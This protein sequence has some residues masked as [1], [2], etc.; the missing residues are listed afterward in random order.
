MRE[1][2]R[3]RVLRILPRARRLAR[4]GRS[5]HGIAVLC[6]VSD[7]TVKRMLDPSFVPPRKPRRP[8]EIWQQN[9]VRTNQCHPAR[10]FPVRPE[11]ARLR[12]QIV[13]DFAAGDT[14]LWA[15]RCAAM[16]RLLPILC[17]VE[18]RPPE[19]RQHNPDKKKENA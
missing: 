13:A 14:D 18:D 1:T 7:A 3:D 6:G 19:Q 11:I 4:L 16:R 2:R 8:P 9:P 12:E 15:E 5:I 17:P 10:Q